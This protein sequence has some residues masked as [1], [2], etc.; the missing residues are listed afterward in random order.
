MTTVEQPVS[1]GDLGVDALIALAGRI[2][3]LETRLDRSGVFA[4]RRS[5]EL[6]LLQQRMDSME[7]RLSLDVVGSMPKRTRGVLVYGVSAICAA[8]VAVIVINGVEV[9]QNSEIAHQAAV[10]GQ[11]IVQ[12]EKTYIADHETLTQQVQKIAQVTGASPKPTAKPK[13][14]V[15]SPRPAVTKTVVRKTAVR[16]TAVRKKDVPAPQMDTVQ[17]VY[18]GRH[19]GTDTLMSDS[20]RSVERETG[21]FARMAP[22]H[23]RHHRDRDHGGFVADLPFAV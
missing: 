23:R 15:A 16:K 10:N 22:H 20:K 19:R 8:A 9:Y 18:K 13:P 1:T 7:S 12:A 11:R 4:M 6:R 21:S 3:T 2:G 17:A 14:V 5:A